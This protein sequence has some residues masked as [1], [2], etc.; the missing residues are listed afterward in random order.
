MRTT[1]ELSD[2][3]Y[4]RLR[5]EAADRGSR[6]FSAIVEEAV[7]LYLEGARERAESAAAIEAARGAWSEDDVE[8]LERALKGA[9]TSGWQIDPSSTPMS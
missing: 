4:R 2:R 5:A 3:T 7:S 9:W 1:I 8:E 6:G